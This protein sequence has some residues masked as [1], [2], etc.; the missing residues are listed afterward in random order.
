MLLP[1]AS[2]IITLPSLCSEVEAVLFMDTRKLA[3]NW[4]FLG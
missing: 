3:G 4:G 1:C 2:V